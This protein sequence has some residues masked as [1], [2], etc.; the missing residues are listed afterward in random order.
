MF[1]NIYCCFIYIV[2]FMSSF[3]CSHVGLNFLFYKIIRVF[4]DVFQ[5][6]PVISTEDFSTLFWAIFPHSNWIQRDTEYSVRMW[7]N[8]DQNNSENGSFLR[9]VFYVPH[10][11]EVLQAALSYLCASKGHFISLKLDKIVK[12]VL[13]E[14]VLSIVQSYVE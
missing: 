10:V 3:L 4:L 8:R 2:G 9:S 6:I 11:N 7:E 12:F 5:H 13:E 14:S 1:L